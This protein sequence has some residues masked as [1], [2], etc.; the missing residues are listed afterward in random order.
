[1]TVRTQSGREWDRP[2][3]F[4]LEDEAPIL[5]LAPHGVVGRTVDLREYFPALRS[6]GQYRITW[7]PYGGDIGITGATITIAPRKHVEMAT[8]HGKLTIQ[9]YYDEA[10]LNVANFID[11]VGSNFFTG[12]TFHRVVPGYMIQGGCPRGD[13]SGIRPDGKRVQAEFNDLPHDRGSLSMALLD[14]NPD[15]A[16]SQFFICYTRQSDWD[17]RYTVFGHLVGDESFETLNRLM[18]VPIDEN[19]RPRETLYIRICLSYRRTE[20]ADALDVAVKQWEKAKR[21][22]ALPSGQSYQNRRSWLPVPEKRVH[23]FGRFRFDG[24]YLRSNASIVV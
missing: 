11:L 21:I 2:V 16:S 20:C 22:F 12:L 3:G 18:A 5:L 9:L 10:P 19:N 15:S 14:D 13:G 23:P 24:T 4:R 6:T 17:G 8:D 7:R 1:V